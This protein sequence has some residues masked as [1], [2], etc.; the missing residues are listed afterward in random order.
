MRP[1]TASV[2]VDPLASCT[3]HW[4]EQTTDHF[5]FAPPYLK[6]YTFQQRYYACDEYYKP[7]KDGKQPPI[8]FYAGNEGPVENYVRHTGLMWEN[9]ERWGAL[10]IFAEHRY[11]GQSLPYGNSSYVMPYIQ[12]LSHEQ[13]MADYVVS[14]P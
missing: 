2:R 11:Y 10:L 8:F 14:R 12:Y 3:E 13:A 9:A 6:Q 1:G 5:N 7:S 4:I